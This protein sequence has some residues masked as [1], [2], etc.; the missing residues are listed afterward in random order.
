MGAYGG[1]REIMQSVAPLGPMYQAGTLSG[2]PLAMAAGIATLKQ[3][4]ADAI[5]ERLDRLGGLLEEGLR[6]AAAQA[7]RPV[8]IN[9]CGSLL[10]MFYADEDVV[11]YESALRSDTSAYAAAH[12][13]LL[14]RGVFFAPSQF[15]AAFISAAHSEEDIAVTI[16]AVADSLRS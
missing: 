11:D 2:N 4:Q 9:R 1:R 3:L 14:E 15:E 8:R 16:E 7:E 6:K 5:Y 13:R 10:T 12:A